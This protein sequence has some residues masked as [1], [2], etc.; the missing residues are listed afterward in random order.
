MNPDMR[1]RTETQSSD[2]EF[3]SVTFS[4]RASLQFD[5]KLHWNIDIT[6]G[7]GTGKI[8]LLKQSLVIARTSLTEFL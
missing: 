3:G 4:N 7:Q 1:G 5:F 2:K 8:C 6:K